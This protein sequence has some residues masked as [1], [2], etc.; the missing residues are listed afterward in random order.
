MKKIRRFIC[1]GIATVAIGGFTVFNASLSSQNSLSAVYLFNVEALTTPENN[2]TCIY[3]SKTTCTTEEF[4][5][6][7]VLGE[8]QC[9]WV[10]TTTVTCNGENAGYVCCEEGTSITYDYD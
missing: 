4:E 2:N 9:V 7:Y 3:R 1:G 10:T 5:Q 8:L 6:M